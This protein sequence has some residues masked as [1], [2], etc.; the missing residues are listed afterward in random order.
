MDRAT[1]LLGLQLKQRNLSHY[2]IN[3]QTLIIGFLTVCFELFALLNN[4]QS[5]F[6]CQSTNN[7]NYAL[8]SCFFNDAFVDQP[9]S[10]SV[11]YS[12]ILGV[13]MLH[14]C[15]LQIFK[16]NVGYV[17]ILE[18]IY[19]LLCGIFAIL[20]LSF[21][22]KIT[23]PNEVV[24]PYTIIGYGGDEQ[25]LAMNCI[26]KLY[27]CFNIFRILL[28]AIQTLLLVVAIV[29]SYF[30]LKMYKQRTRTKRDEEIALN[31]L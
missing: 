5:M 24:C 12:I 22:Q 25:H 10:H 4:V 14:V 17:V 6:V 20:L 19:I 15:I 16:I 7:Y 8:S 9:L 23:L 21:N 18:Y 30:D 3:A 27:W 29:T 28:C 26:S 1:N 2:I 13:V 31:T 11:L